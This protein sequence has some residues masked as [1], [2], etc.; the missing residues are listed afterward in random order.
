MTELNLLHY[1]KGTL[2]NMYKQMESERDKLDKMVKIMEKYL[3]LIYD[4]GFDCDGL[5]EIESLKVLVEQLTHYASLGRVA[6]TT[7]PIFVKGKT[8]YNILN[9]K[10]KN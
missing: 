2:V 7:E 4:I 3:E 5:N 10:I 9:E 8:K 6:N 1:S